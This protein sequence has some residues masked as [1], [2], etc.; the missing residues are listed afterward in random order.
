MLADEHGMKVKFKV[1]PLLHAPSTPM[2]VSYALEDIVKGRQ[3][4]EMASSSH[5]SHK[6]KKH[7]KKKHHHQSHEP[8]EQVQMPTT[9]GF[10]G[11]VSD[12]MDTGVTG[13]GRSSSYL[14]SYSRG[15]VDKMKMFEHWQTTGEDDTT[16]KEEQFSLPVEID[17]FKLTLASRS[18]HEH[19]KKKKKKHKHRESHQIM[20][21]HQSKIRIE[22]TEASDP[23]EPALAEEDRAPATESVDIWQV[24]HTGGKE[25][26]HL[27]VEKVKEL[28]RTSLTPEVEDSQGPFSRDSDMF[29]KPVV[30]PTSSVQ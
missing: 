1:A 14:P 12:D 17:L 10:S 9:S 28:D 24:Q 3:K 21:E 16:R 15:P 27:S 29:L 20:D 7:K 2:T 5:K 8:A 19:K 26:R 13:G 25:K 23:Q 18:S 30:S 11:S 6:H 4:E 22:V